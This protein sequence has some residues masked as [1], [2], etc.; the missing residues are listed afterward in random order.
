MRPFD[1]AWFARHQG[2]LLALL[3]EP[4]L[5]RWC[6]WVLCIRRHD[7][8]YAAPIVR[9]LPH[10]Y[11]VRTPSVSRRR[12]AAFAG[13]RPRVFA[14]LQSTGTYTA[15]IRTHPKYAKRLYDAFRPLWWLCH[16]WDQW[17]ANPLRPAWNLGFDT[18]PAAYPDPDPETTTFDGSVVRSGVDEP[19]ST[20]RSGAGTGVDDTVVWLRG[21]SFI[22]STTTNQ[23]AT[24]WRAELV[25]DTSGIGAA[26]DVSAA[27]LSLYGNGQQADPTGNAPNIDI[28]ASSPASYTGATATD[29]SGIGSVSQTGAP[30]SYAG[31]LG[32]AYNAFT[33]NPTGRATIVKTG[34]SAFAIRNPNYDVAN[35]APAWASGAWTYIECYAADQAGK[36]NDPKLVVTY[37][38]T[39]IVRAAFRVDAQLVPAT[40]TSLA[41]DLSA[42]EGLSLRRGLGGSGP[43]DR[44]APTGSCTFSLR[45]HAG[46]SGSTQGWYSPNH[47]SVRAG[48]TFG[49]P[50]RVVATY[51]GTDYTLWTGKLRAVDPIPG[52]YREQRVT[53]TAY[54]CMNDLAENDVR[55]VAPQVN[56]TE[57]T[58]I[59]A[60]IAA[61]ATEAQPVAVTYDTSLETYPYALDNA[62]SDVRALSLLVD[63]VTSA[64]AFAYPLANGTLHIEN[65]QARALADSAFTFTDATLDDVEVSTD[66]SN[67]YNR[68]RVTIH[69][70]VIDAAATTVLF[71]IDGVEV[72]PPGETVTLWGDYAATDNVLQLIGGTAQ[73]TPI[74][75]TTDYMANSLE[76]G[77]G[78]NLTSSM[79][80]VTTAYAA[81]VKFEVTNPTAQTAYLV[82]GAGAPLLQVRGKGIYDETPTSRD[83]FSTQAYGDR[84][85][86]VDL[87][88]QDNSETAK[89]LADFLLAQYAT[90]GD[91]IQSLAFN[92]Q[93]SDTLMLQALTGEI[94]SIV[95]VTE[96]MTGLV[97][98]EAVIQAIELDVAPGP[99][100]AV[101]YLV[102]PRGPTDLFILDDAARGI[103]DTSVL[104]YA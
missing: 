9:L 1:A 12:S 16:G 48:W 33:L 24:L 58:I 95:T 71:G 2:L 27:V 96:T 11:V 75:A 14:S 4:L 99:F 85:L 3:A 94:G 29:Y 69:P 5:G 84:R 103:L 21:V 40:W 6:R 72:V 101:R 93:K 36:A 46:N 76:D 78:T 15:D 49:I 65:R 68:V 81:A 32:S 77:S 56:Q 60:L 39:G 8:G 64:Q 34:L 52:R 92:P 87:R 57:N 17:I 35:V 53:C 80:I 30:I 23:W 20:L 70:R 74:V 66:L 28:Y 97:S 104:S 91:Q 13:F 89:G 83:A 102:A 26:N 61:L 63:V 7:V 59:A 79:T 54:D 51:S 43:T 42:A 25:F 90:I 50:I 100:L 41:A 45:N 86:D 31:W 55:A 47:A 22:A 73:V 67:V 88:Y 38:L 19:W 82:T 10:A 37:T 18:L 98:V 44:V 62:A